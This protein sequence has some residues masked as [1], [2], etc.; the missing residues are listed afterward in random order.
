M[1]NVAFLLIDTVGFVGNLLQTKNYP[2]KE[3]EEWIE[4]NIK[5]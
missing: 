4:I 5:M 3:F 2:N 1:I